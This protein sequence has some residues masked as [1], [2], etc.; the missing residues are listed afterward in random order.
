MEDDDALDAFAA[1]V[2]LEGITVTAPEGRE[3]DSTFASE[4]DLFGESDPDSAV[5]N[6]D[7][8]LAGGGG[9]GT[10]GGG[11]GAGTGMSLSN[12]NATFNLMKSMG[13]IDVPREGQPSFVEPYDFLSIL[14]SVQKS[15]GNPVSPTLPPYVPP[16]LVPVLK[17]QL[18]KIV[19]V[20]QNPGGKGYTIAVNPSYQSLLGLPV[21]QDPTGQFTNPDDYTD[22]S[23]R[24]NQ[25]LPS[26]LT[27]DEFDP[28]PPAVINT[29]TPISSYVPPPDQGGQVNSYVPPPDQGGQVNSYVSPTD[30]GS[31]VSPYSYVPPTDQGGQVSPFDVNDPY[32]MWT[33]GMPGGESIYGPGG[34]QEYLGG[35]DTSGRNFDFSDMSSGRD[36]IAQ[37]MMQQEKAA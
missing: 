29:R 2:P 24:R 10:Q 26:A 35:I 13:L 27:F 7:L 3:G 5:S 19:P 18:D 12:L 8:E 6:L 34:I 17:Q 23:I 25:T 1:D 32:A 37:A 36:L 16:E 31:Q 21:H 9:H 4:E 14:Q 20:T 33:P 30:Q 22:D 15:L 11:I 28:N